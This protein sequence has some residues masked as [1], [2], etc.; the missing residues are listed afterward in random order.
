MVH[1]SCTVIGAGLVGSATALHLNHLGFS[2]RILDRRPSKMI[3]QSDSR[4][5]VLSHSSKKILCELDLWSRLKEHL[6]PIMEIHVTEARAFGRVML[7]SK[8]VGLEALGWS[9]EAGLLL[10]VLRE[11]VQNSDSIE[12]H[13][14]TEVAEMNFIDGVW[15]LEGSKKDQN[16]RIASDLLVAADGTD[17]IVCKFL[18]VTVDSIDYDQSAIVSTLNTENNLGNKAYLRFLDKGSMALIPTASGQVVSVLCVPEKVAEQVKGFSD[19]SFM[20]FLEESFGR[21]LGKSL[22]CGPRRKYAI[23]RQSLSKTNYGRCVILGNAANTLHPNGAQGLNLGFRD[24]LA[25]GTCLSERTG[26]L[27]E[28]LRIYDSKRRSDHVTTGLYSDLLAQLFASNLGLARLTRR[29]LMGLVGNVRPLKRRFILRS[30]GLIF[31]SA[32]N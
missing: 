5:L 11:A 8:D 26:D 2:V 13:W 22:R 9:C 21:R 16:L 12:T 32:S 4:A 3:C 24:V 20:A 17:S 10:S 28:A 14:N 23:R 1:S 27:D 19:E 15:M 30:T 6:L 29:T 31:F 18:E 25:L 7:T